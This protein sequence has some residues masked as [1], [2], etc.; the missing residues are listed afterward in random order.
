MTR[1]ELEKY[2]GKNVKITLFD[3]DVIIGQL[4]KTGEGNF[5]NNPNLYI[6]RNRYFCILDTGGISCVFRVSHIKS[7]KE[8]G[9]IQNDRL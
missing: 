6:P 8:I 1:T 2:L 9:V 5:K 7:L 4:H 3:G